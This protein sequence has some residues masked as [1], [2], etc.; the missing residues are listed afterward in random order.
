MPV[1]ATTP[2]WWEGLIKTGEQLL[3]QV[4]YPKGTYVQT[5]PTGGTI[6]YR[7]PG[8]TQPSI[9]TA[10]AG[11][12]AVSGVASPGVGMILLAGGAFFLV[13]MLARGK[14]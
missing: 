13:M 14:K 11:T 7:Q 5:S 9:L 10:G 4:T 6:T 3:L 2:S 1:T 8:G 12:A